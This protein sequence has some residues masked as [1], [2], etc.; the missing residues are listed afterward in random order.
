MDGGEATDG[1]NASD[2]G[3]AM[4]GGS[5]ADG[6]S[7]FDGGGRD[8]G[9]RDGG[10]NRDGGSTQDGGPANDGGATADGGATDDGGATADGGTT[11]CLGAPDLTACDDGDPTTWGDVCFG[12]SCQSLFQATI[13]TPPPT[14]IPI[15]ATQ[16]SG[17]VCRPGTPDVVY[18]AGSYRV[19]LGGTAQT[20]GGL[21]GID[22]ADLSSPA[23]WGEPTGMVAP[24]RAIARVGDQGFVAVGLSGQIAWF[25]S[26]TSSSNDVAFTRVTADTSHDYLGTFGWQPP[27]SDADGGVPGQFYVVGSMSYARVCPYPPSFMGASC[28]QTIPIPSNRTATALTGAL[29]SSALDLWAVSPTGEI[30]FYTTAAAVSSFAFDPPTGCSPSGNGPPACKFNG[31]LTDISA[32]DSQHVWATG[33]GAG[34]VLKY[35]AL[36][37]VGWQ[38]D[39]PAPIDSTARGFTTVFAAPGATPDDGIFV[40]VVARQARPNNQ[41][42]LDYYAQVHG[43]W[44]GPFTLVTFPNSLGDVYRLNDA[45]GCSADSPIFAG[46]ARDTSGVQQSVI[47]T[48]L[49][50]PF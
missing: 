26:I 10:P 7:G 23:Q 50:N 16:L 5:M 6:G 43:A 2:G 38:L 32:A 19:N 21:V 45:T 33:S 30:P 13:L 46:S 35:D 8:G 11:S 12:G 28:S 20:F 31:V 15:E 29:S 22:P 4:D 40:H 25:S 48:P 17:I 47:L 41:T 27:S 18:G 9:R 39:T 49:L 14:P 36:A 34:V 3:V 42:S 24:L 1:G 44:Q 37:N